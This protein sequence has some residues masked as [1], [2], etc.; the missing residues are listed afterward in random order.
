MSEKQRLDAELVAR[1]IIQSREQAKAAIM[2][3]Q[4]YVNGQKC[5]K[6]GQMVDPEKGEC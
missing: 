3:G 5:D 6:A 1:G 4:V 2:A